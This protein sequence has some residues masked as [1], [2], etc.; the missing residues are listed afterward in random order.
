M[1]GRCL[2]KGGKLL[3]EAYASAGTWVEREKGGRASEKDIGNYGLL[4]Y[5][6]FCFFYLISKINNKLTQ[7]MTSIPIQKKE[8]NY[9]F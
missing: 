3:E 8:A 7:R 2:R 5:V 9:F 4:S 1:K 6:L